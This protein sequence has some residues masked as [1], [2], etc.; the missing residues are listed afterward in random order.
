MKIRRVMGYAAAVLAVAV[1]IVMIFRFAP[2][3]KIDTAEV[4][5]PTVPVPSEE[6]PA[7]STK[8]DNTAVEVRP[9]T[10]QAVIAMLT[11]ADSYSRVLTAE[12][13]WSGGGS[14]KQIHVWARGGSMRISIPE[15]DKEKNILIV[16]DEV[17]IWYSDSKNIYHGTAAEGAADEYQELAT[18]EEL[19]EVEETDIQDAGYDEYEGE[20]CIFAEYSSG[21]FG[22]TTKL[23]ISVQTGL[24]MCSETWDGTELLHRVTSSAP[25]ISTPV[26]AVFELPGQT[27]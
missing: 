13:R 9:D 23:W 5:L 21:E 25:D 6:L 22:Y 24:L 7:Q 10:V 27:D 11:R 26:E 18:Y 20:Y 19:L 1:V 2:S 8:P 15:E 3:G 14:T 12:S 16:E 4:I 17:W